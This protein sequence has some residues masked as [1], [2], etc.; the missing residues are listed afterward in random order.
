[1]ETRQ[2]FIMMLM[3]LAGCSDTKE[4]RTD[5]EWWGVR[6][7]C[8][9]YVEAL[10]DCNEAQCDAIAAQFE[11]ADADTEDVCAAKLADARNGTDASCETGGDDDTGSV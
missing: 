1:M 2:L 5:D 10:C 4:E 3:V 11:N 6:G 8:D 9:D 7:A